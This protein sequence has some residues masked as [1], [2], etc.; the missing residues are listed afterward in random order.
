MV[1]LRHDVD[2]VEDENKVHM[3]RWETHPLEVTTPLGLGHD[4]VSWRCEN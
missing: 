4:F 3:K 2:K 1:N